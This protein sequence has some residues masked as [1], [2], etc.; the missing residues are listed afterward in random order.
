VK[1]TNRKDHDV[2]P[3]L[4]GGGEMGELTRNYD[5]SNSTLGTPDTWPLSLR[6]TLGIVLHSAFPMFLFWGEDLICFYNDAFRPSLGANGKHPALG[7]KGREVWEEIWAQVGSMIEG[8]MQSGEPV[9]FEDQLIPFYRNGAIE[10]IYWTFSYSPAYGDNGKVAGVFVTCCETTRNVK[11]LEKLTK[12]DKRFQSLIQKA[13]VGIIVVTGE[14]NIVEIVNEAY[15]E[16][17]NYAYEDLISMPLFEIVPEAKKQFGKIIEDVRT[18]GTPYQLTDYPY[19]IS[20]ANVYKEGFLNL[21]YQPYEEDGCIIG[22][23]ILCQDVTQEVNASKV[24]EKNE[25]QIRSI[26]ES[27]PFPI[28]VYIGRKMRISIANQSMLDTWGKGDDVIGRLYSE[29]LPELSGQ[30]IFEQ[31]EEVFRTGI[32]FHARN[33]RVDIVV[34]EKLQPF[35]FNY[36]FTPLYDLDGSVYGVMNTAADVTDL[37]LAKQKIEQSEKN[38]RDIILQAPI[39]MCLMIGP[40]HTVEIANEVMINLWGKPSEEVLDRPIFEGL[41][42]ARE[43]GLEELLDHVYI[44][45]ETF[46]ASEMPV[47]LVRFGVPEIIYQNFVYEPYRQSDGKIL[48]VLAISVDVTEQVRARQQIEQTVQDR[49]VELREANINLQ[50]S[51]S[52][53]AQF[54]YIASHDLQEP[55]RKIGIFSQMLQERIA[56]SDDQVS[57]NNIDKIR[58]SV[59]RMQNLVKDVL[60][61]SQLTAEGISYENVDLNNIMEATI[62][63]YEL[64]IESKDAL[65]DYGP[66]PTIAA[67]PL[68][69]AQLFGN[70]I[71]NALKFTH[72]DRKPLIK[73]TAEF[74]SDTQKQ[75]F[76]FPASDNLLQLRFQDNGI[77][78]KPTYAEK[79]FN[80]FQRLH[81]KTEYEGTGIGLSLCKKIAE[82][83]G[84]VINTQGSSEHGAVFNVI[85]SCEHRETFLILK[86]SADGF[87]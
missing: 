38:F 15:L 77:G 70:M 25:Q 66:L 51:N 4:G 10:D 6:T 44:S 24:V 62:S 87:E 63:D 47:A 43:Q 13:A 53:L 35:Y 42:D 11:T 56:G 8:V 75:R 73:I 29:I 12:S 20:N 21:I 36:S 76:G 2:P 71:S 7:K 16:L 57:K 33:Q 72:P 9:Y 49:T 23:M 58:I 84:G 59:V 60:A 19:H 40:N 22:V 18:T 3:F 39:A 69:M 46:M 17:V 14:Y 28:G 37:N 64:I 45:G 82:N 55:L 78:F 86:K 54:A 52:E 31:L 81:A 26:V 79:I 34:N 1:A 68:Q 50:R 80:I 30:K 5:W 85:L 41:P 65:I 74:L 67:I 48:G 32:P 83:H 27:A 61:Y